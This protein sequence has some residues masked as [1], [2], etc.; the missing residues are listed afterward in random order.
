MSKNIDDWDWASSFGGVVDTLYEGYGWEELT[1]TTV[2][3]YILPLHHVWNPETRDSAKGPIMFMHGAGGDSVSSL[4]F[5]PWMREL[6]DLGH[7]FYLANNRGN[8]LALDHVQYDY[9]E[10]Q[11]EFW[12]FSF[13]E[14]ANDITASAKVMSENAG[15]GKGWYFGYSQGT[16]QGMVALATQEDEMAKY[17]NRVILL[18]P[19]FGTDEDYDMSQLPESKRPGYVY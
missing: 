3:G 9:M 17:F 10:D 19:C 13:H 1:V 18:A 8:S 4:A 12:D 5:Y 7:D 2:D 11:K 16:I 15:T 6:I 14:F